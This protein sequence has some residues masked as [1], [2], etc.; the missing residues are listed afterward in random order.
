MAPKDLLNEFQMLET[1]FRI[2]K[3]IAKDRI[4]I[5]ARNFQNILILYMLGNQKGPFLDLVKIKIS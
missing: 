3:L 1:D 4:K 2:E 5:L